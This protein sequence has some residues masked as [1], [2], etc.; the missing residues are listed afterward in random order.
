MLENMSVE[1]AYKLTGTKTHASLAKWL[2]KTRT[3]ISYYAK[4]GIPP[5]VERDIKNKLSIIKAERAEAKRLKGV[6]KI[7]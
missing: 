4:N 6:H 3:I 5:A 2:G 1:E 7:D